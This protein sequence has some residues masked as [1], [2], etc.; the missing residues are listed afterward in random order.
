M[1]INRKLW[2]GWHRELHTALKT[3]DRDKAVETFINLHAMVHSRRISKD[4]LHSFEDELLDGI[5]PIQFRQTPPHFSHSIAWIIWHLARI[6]DITMNILIADS[7]QIFDRDSWA[8]KLNIKAAHAG[9][10]MPHSQMLKISQQIDF[11]ELRK[12]RQAVG[13]QTRKIVK[14][15]RPEQYQQAVDPARIKRIRD[16]RAMLPEAEGVVK[17]WSRRTIAGLLLMPPT[18]HCFFHLNE[19]GRIRQKLSKK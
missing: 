15:I 17:Y 7:Q 3:G 12:Y 16:E 9:N 11:E 6:E 10:N 4:G 5:T 19:A 18:R 1:E 8:D 2:N 14:K 13:R